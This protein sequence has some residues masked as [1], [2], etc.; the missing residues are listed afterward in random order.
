MWYVLLWFR[1]IPLYGS[2]MALSPNLFQSA[3][4]CLTFFGVHRESCLRE[5]PSSLQHWRPRNSFGVGFSNVGRL[6][7]DACFTLIYLT[8]VEVFTP[9]SSKNCVA[10]LWLDCRNGCLKGDEFVMNHDESWS[11]GA[12]FGFAKSFMA[13]GRIHHN[14]PYGLSLHLPRL[15]SVAIGL[16]V[17]EWAQDGFRGRLG[18]F[19]AMAQAKSWCG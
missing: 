9:V 5:R 16:G 3:F 8:V 10:N 19:L 15:L 11:F 14:M 6:F 2:D 12:A 18:F 17:I 4:A 7:L 13:H 1:Y